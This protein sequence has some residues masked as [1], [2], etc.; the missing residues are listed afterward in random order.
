MTKDELMNSYF[1]MWSSLLCVVHKF[2]REI[3]LLKS[4]IMKF[5]FGLCALRPEEISTKVAKSRHFPVDV[6]YIALS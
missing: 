6:R 3:A 2:L 1:A 5:I 4:G